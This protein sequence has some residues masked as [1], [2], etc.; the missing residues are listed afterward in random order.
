MWQY[1]YT[2]DYLVH[3]GVKG[4]KWGRRLY[5]YKDG[6]LTPLGKLRYRKKRK[7]AQAKRAATIDAK[8]KSADEEKTNQ[9]ALEKKKQ[10][11]IKSQ[12][13]KAIY[14][15]MNLFTTQE[16][17]ELSQRFLYAKQ[18]KDNRP[19]P[20]KVSK[21]KAFIDKA[22][23]I[24]DTTKKAVDSANNLAGS[25]K[26]ANSMLGGLKKKAEGAANTSNTN[27]QSSTN[28]KTETAT[29]KVFGEGTSKRQSDKTEKKAT[30]DTIIDAE[31][32]D[33][34]KEVVT[35]IA[36]EVSEIAAIGRSYIAAL[37][38]EPR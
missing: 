24:I 38:D 23:G 20:E 8:K 30:K 10:E 29:G 27:Q 15:N 32:R 26:K 3:D 22:L 11:I 13:G 25:I 17:Q 28:N 4:M 5:Q 16:L 14:D 9:E 18:I 6:S 31:W 7:Q 36:P 21:G 12:S 35:D 2:E 33:L 1:N 37:L 34:T 19:E